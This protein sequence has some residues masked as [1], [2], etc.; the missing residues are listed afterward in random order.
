MP[1]GERLWKKDKMPNEIPFGPRIATIW[2]ELVEH[3][4]SIS[5]KQFA[6][7]LQPHQ[8]S[9]EKENKQCS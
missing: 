2:R 8:P 7:S 4:N 9:E 3:L 1:V 6:P 5:R